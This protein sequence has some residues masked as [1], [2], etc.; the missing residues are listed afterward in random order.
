[1]GAHERPLFDKLLWRLVTS[2]IFVRSLRLIAKKLAEL[3]CFHRSVRTF[4]AACSFDEL[5]RGFVSCL[6][7]ASFKKQ[8]PQHHNSIFYAETNDH[9]VRRDNTGRILA[10]WRRS[11]ASRVSPRPAVLGDAFGNVPPDPHGHR[12]GQQISCIFS[13]VDYLSCI[14]VAK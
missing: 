1:M 2:T 3:F 14:T 12:N 10:R 11:V 5:S 7:N 8:F 13:V 6:L 4:Y 9:G